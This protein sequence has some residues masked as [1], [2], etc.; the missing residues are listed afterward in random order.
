MRHYHF[1]IVFIF[2]GSLISC[3]QNIRISGSSAF[4]ESDTALKTNVDVKALTVKFVESD[5]SSFQKT[6]LNNLHIKELELL[7][8]PQYA[9]DFVLSELADFQLEKLI[10]SNFSSKAINLMVELPIKEIELYCENPLIHVM[11]SGNNS[12]GIKKLTISG[13]KISALLFDGDL[14]SLKELDCFTPSLK[15]FPLFFSK[16]IERIRLT[17]ADMNLE[18]VFCNLTKIELLEINSSILNYK[19]YCWSELVYNGAKVVFNG[20]EIQ[21]PHADSI[22]RVVSNDSVDYDYEVTSFPGGD[23]AMNKFINDNL[24]YP[25]D[26]KEKGEHGKFYVGFIVD[27]YGFLQKIRIV[28]GLSPVFDNEALRIVKMMPSWSPG[29][30]NEKPVSTNV[31]IPIV[32]KL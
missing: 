23:N 1:V 13:E 26:A 21:K 20:E 16:D 7:D 22:I 30:E 2:V 15:A 12:K 32:F 24:V 25:A 27:I 14:N 8:P 11:F 17:S 28:R 18:R 31:V 9:I 3:A 5:I 6:I 4:I 10:N 29:K 19:S